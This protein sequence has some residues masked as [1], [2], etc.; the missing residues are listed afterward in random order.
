MRL[1][2]QKKYQNESE[3]MENFEIYS[4]KLNAN[5]KEKYDQAYKEKNIFH[6]NTIFK[7]IPISTS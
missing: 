5:G 1:F 6:R 2:L 4:C 3:A 7:N